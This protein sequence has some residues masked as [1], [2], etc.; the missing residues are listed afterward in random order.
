MHRN[1]LHSYILTMKD[2]KEKLNNPSYYCSRKNKIPR[3]EPTWGGKRLSLVA[4]KVKESACNAG[5]LGS[6][7]K[8]G[9]SPGE[10]NGN[11]LQY[12]CLESSHAQRSLAGCS[13]WG[14]KELDT[15]EWLTLLL[16]RRYLKKSCV[17]KTTRKKWKISLIYERNQRWHKQMERYTV[18]LGWKN[19]YHE[20]DY[21]T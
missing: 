10:R 17:Q 13:P 5:D 3:N 14:H 20:N 4:Q 1:L 9:R 19:Q 8:S 6:I 2:E 16:S 12:F 18:F 15:I 7:P 11:P 21:T